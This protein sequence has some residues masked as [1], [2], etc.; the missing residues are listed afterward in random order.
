MEF[1]DKM[2]LFVFPIIVKLLNQIGIPFK[3]LGRTVLGQSVLITQ[4]KKING[5]LLAEPNKSAK[6]IYFLTMIGGH[7]HNVAID[8]V[9]GFG[10]KRKGHNI[11]F[12]LDDNF[13]PIN[14]DKKLGQENRWVKISNRSYYFGKL[15]LE[16]SGFEVVNLSSLIEK[17]NAVD[18][19]DFDL[20]KA[21]SL[22]K[23]YKIGLIPD[24]L[25]M[26]NQKRKLVTEATNYSAQ[27]GYYI[28]SKKPDFVVMSHGIY[29]TWGPPFKI[30]VE[31]G[32]PVLTYSK[33]KRKKTEKF[34]WNTTGDWWEV[35]NE[36]EKVKHL[37]LTMDQ[38]ED[39]DAYLQSRV[40]HKDDVLQ[41]NFGEFE[42]EDA[43]YKRF[44]INPELPVFSLF[45]NVLWD[46]ASAQ[47]ELVFSNP[48]EWVIETIDWFKD[49]KDYQL[50][51][52]VHPAEVVIGTNQSFESII[53]S[54][55][56]SL[57]PNVF[58]IGPR[59]EVNSWSIYGITTMG[60]VHT[61][62]AGME[63]PLVGKPCIVVSKTHFRNKGF[64]IDVPDKT[65][66]FNTIKHYTKHL[67]NGN[68]LKTLSKRYAYL[69]FERYQYPF[70]VFDEVNWTD[71]RSFN[72]NSIDELFEIPYFELLIESIVN[73]RDIL[74]PM[75]G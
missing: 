32:I 19:K 37:P 75:D 33:T 56:N 8:T 2:K 44:G 45:T 58:L 29:S 18:T 14:E 68:E 40:T 25:P 41:Y 23:H 70:D 15:L 43:T 38:R 5:T 4:G 69:L 21:A 46:A 10:L 42:G 35:G 57:P 9:L 72:F 13:L 74:K 39:I 22:L 26:I 67:K 7:T 34:N 55:F 61:T 47:R 11:K 73:Q 36:W 60:I 62:T 16:N 27:L 3:T 31:A 64:T 17:E 71:V 65:Q 20:I 63:L 51:I 54:R 49:Q 28:K 66:Y 53:K 12:I 48:I 24:D 30:L 59:E 50:L 6:T 52:K 1:K